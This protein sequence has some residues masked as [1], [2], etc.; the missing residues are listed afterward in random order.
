MKVEIWS[1]VVCPWCYIGKR[2]FEAALSQFPHADEVSI[3]WK[4]F[5]LDPRAPTLRETNMDEMLQRKYGMTEEQA[6]AANEKMTALAAGVGLDFQLDKAQM[7]NTFDAHRLIHL[8]TR[9]GLGGAMNERLL[10]AYFTEGRSIGR[11]RLR[12]GSWPSRSDS[13]RQRS[14]PP[15]PGTPTHQACSGT[16][17]VLGPSV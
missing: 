9:H 5:E 10:A 11:P 2:H 6:V 13:I 12:S 4:S 7:G 3:E 1:D 8:A 17:R 15:W 14:R 16:K